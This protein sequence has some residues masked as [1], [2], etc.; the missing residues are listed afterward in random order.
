MGAGASTKQAAA[1]GAARSEQAVEAQSKVLAATAALEAALLEAAAAGLAAE[2]IF[3]GVVARATEFATKSL[4]LGPDM[5][6]A[7]LADEQLATAHEATDLTKLAPAL[8]R[9]GVLAEEERVKQAAETAACAQVAI[10]DDVESNEA[11][12]AVRAAHVSLKAAYDD[13]IARRV[14]VDGLFQMAAQAVVA[15]GDSFRQIYSSVWA[16]VNKPDVSEAEDQQGEG[17]GMYRAAVRDLLTPQLLRPKTPMAELQAM[18]D[19]TDMVEYMRNAAVVMVP[20]GQIVSAI[21]A[22]AEERYGFRVVHCRKPRTLKKMQRIVEKVSLRPERDGCIA[23]VCDCVRMMVPVRKMAH[24]A[25]LLRVFCD[26]ATTQP[27]AARL[28]IDKFALVRAKERFLESPSSGGWRDCM[29]NFLIVFGGSR[30]V[31]ELQ[32]VHETMLSARAGLPGH[33]IYNRVRNASELIELKM[34]ST[35]AADAL[36]LAALRIAIGDESKDAS[37]FPERLDCMV[38]DSDKLQPSFDESGQ[39]SSLELRQRQ[40]P[41]A[42]L[43]VLLSALGDG[44]WPA[45]SALRL[46]EHDLSDEDATRIVEGSVMSG[47]CLNLAGAS[48]VVDLSDRNLSKA[49]VRLVVASLQ[50]GAAITLLEYAAQCFEPDSPHVVSAPADSCDSLVLCASASRATIWRPKQAT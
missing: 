14:D 50:G 31:T 39:L 17:V 49:D 37:K 23:S 40:I 42:A 30:Q 18:K 1:D 24:V 19:S 41:N 45:L 8:R 22:A 6:N 7:A 12:A 5:I 48:N 13:A 25:N 3:K 28:G 16:L 20:F 32:I 34:G 43:D 44:M 35:I 9:F 46:V 2:S 15:G 47:R 11:E 38:F 21:V 29:L 4:K 27:I 10:V 26:E 36:R 33:A